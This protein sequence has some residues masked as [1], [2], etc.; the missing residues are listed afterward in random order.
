MVL[1][2]DFSGYKLANTETYHFLLNHNSHD[3]LKIHTENSGISVFLYVGCTF[4]LGPFL[5]SHQGSS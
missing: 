4:S 3:I 2:I 1:E 5:Q